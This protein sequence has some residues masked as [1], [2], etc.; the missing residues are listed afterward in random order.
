[1]GGQAQQGLVDHFPV[2]GKEVGGQHDD[3]PD[4]RRAGQ[5]RDRAQQPVGQAADDLDGPLRKPVEGFAHIL[6][7]FIGDRLKQFFQTL[8]KI[9]GHLHGGA[10]V[11]G[12]QGG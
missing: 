4:D 12:Q 9:V 8:E 1:G 5:R 10:L 2:G 11:G 7:H 6:G 3:D